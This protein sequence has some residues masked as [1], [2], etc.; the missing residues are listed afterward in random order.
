MLAKIY[1]TLKKGV[2]DPQGKAVRH[3]LE[4]LGYKEVRDIRLGKYMEV[5]F[6]DIER[7][8]A[9]TRIREMCEKLLTNPV[10]EDY[11]FEISDE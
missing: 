9:D 8:K 10:I 11:Q 1:V 7:D 5:K 4:S 3:S 2:L 6:G